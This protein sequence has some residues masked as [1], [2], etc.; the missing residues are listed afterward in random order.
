MRLLRKAFPPFVLLLASTTGAWSAQADVTV[1]V[2]AMIGEATLVNESV[3]GKKES[4]VVTT[5]KTTRKDPSTGQTL[6]A[7]ATVADKVN[8]VVQ[9]IAASAPDAGNQLSSEDGCSQGN[10]PHRTTPQ[11]GHDA[12][13]AAALKKA[14]EGLS[15]GELMM[16]MAVLINNAKHLCIDFSTVANTVSLIATVRPEEAANV[17]FVAALLDPDHSDLYTQEAAKAAPAQSSNIDQAKKDADDIKK[18]PNAVIPPRSTSPKPP[19]VKNKPPVK[20]SDIPPG[21]SIGKPPS[22]E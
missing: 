2:E 9:A 11:P 12:A 4:I 16:V 6:L 8:T 17:V 18:D 7:P 1:N 22:P 15:S 5:G 20:P 3:G 19:P 21:G 14:L 13:A 10:A